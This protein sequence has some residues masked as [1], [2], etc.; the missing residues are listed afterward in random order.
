VADL[1]LYYA[2]MAAD[3]ENEQIG[4]AISRD[5]AAFERAGRGGLILAR[6]PEVDWRSLRVCNPT[7][8]LEEGGFLM[9]FQGIAH[10]TQH[11]SIGVARSPDG[12]EWTVED[13]PALPW[14]RMAEV[15]PGLD[16]SRRVGLIEPALLREG[17]T[18]RMWFVYLH[19]SRPGN[20]L[21]YAESEDL[22]AWDLRPAPLVSG[23]DFGR[24]R[25]HY[26]QLVPVEGGYEL[27]FMLRSVE[28]GADG[29]FRMR[30]P[31]GIA[32]EGL[33]QLLPFS[34]DGVALEPRSASAPGR[35]GRALAWRYHKW[36]RGGR[37]LLGYGHPHV[38]GDGR[39]MYYQGAHVGPRG[40]WFD[41]GRAELRGGRWADAGPVLA[42]AGDRAAWDAVFVADPFVLEVG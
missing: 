10:G 6:D 33:E 26:P 40:R 32:L 21:F 11:V 17:R 39:V 36:L 20:A 4:L 22:R 25:L 9:V 27:Y 8:L 34:P 35:V 41:V 14:E 5:G 1:Y 13:P 12:I 31:D 18:Y 3:Q 30:S 28:N 29:I 16:P 38:V 37:N 24:Y 7:V 2:G 19:A 15:D 23:R 42:P